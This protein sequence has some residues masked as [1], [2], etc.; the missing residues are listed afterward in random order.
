MSAITFDPSKKLD[1]YF[2]VARDGSKTFTFVDTASN[3]YNISGFTHQI[4][5]YDRVGGNAL[6]TL[7]EGS[8]IS[9]P[10]NYSVTVTVTD[11]QTVLRPN[12]YFYV[13][14][15]TDGSSLVKTW[16]SGSAIFHEG[17]FD[18]VTETTSIIIDESGTA[19]TVTISDSADD[20]F[21]FNRQT[22]DYTLAL[23]DK[24]KVVETNKATA[25][26]VTVPPN[27]S[28]AFPIGSYVFVA[29]YGAGQTT[30]AA[31]SGV[32]LRYS[33]GLKITAQYDQIGLMKVGTNEWYVSGNLSA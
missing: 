33:A 7:S 26:T 15:R 32:T 2:R 27:S 23:T 8:S 4:I 13:W 30:I 10:D 21:S 18:G 5:I 24:F 3:D 6:L 9:K 20:Y 1:L 19:V 25:N 28:V 22:D 31:G 12:K 14:N 11:T 17:E 16:F 29:Q